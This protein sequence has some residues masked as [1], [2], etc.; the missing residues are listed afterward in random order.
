LENN[1]INVLRMLAK[2]YDP[3]TNEKIS[4]DDVCNKAVVIRALYDAI[5]KLLLYDG[6]IGAIASAKKKSQGNHKKAGLPWEADEDQRLCLEYKNGKTI[7]DL[8]TIHQRTKGAISARLV[9]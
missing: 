3:V 8:S 2:G 4:E 6:P 5:Q 9:C 1:T 7:G